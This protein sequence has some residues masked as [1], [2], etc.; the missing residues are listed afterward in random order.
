MPDGVGHG[1]NAD[2]KYDSDGISEAVD[3]VMYTMEG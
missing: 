1:G 2:G 3:G